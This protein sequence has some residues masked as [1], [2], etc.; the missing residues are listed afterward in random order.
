MKPMGLP[1]FATHPASYAANTL[2]AICL[3][4]ADSDTL[5]VLVD[6]PFGTASTQLVRIDG[7][8]APSTGSKDMTERA[9]GRAAKEWMERWV[10]GRPL[11][12]TTR[13]DAAA[14]MYAAGVMYWRERNESTPRQ[15][16]ADLV[17]NGLASYA[18][19]AAVGAQYAQPPVEQAA[20]L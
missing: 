17:A 4:V 20:T 1:H 5:M 8:T 9:A 15:L 7:I 6:G 12:L 16:A 14:G 13:W 10:A 3:M 19:N 11:L 2:R 18:P